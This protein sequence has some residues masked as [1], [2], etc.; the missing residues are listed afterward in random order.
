MQ[1]RRRLSRG[2]Q[3]L[4]SYTWA[5]SFDTA[6]AG[7][8]LGNPGNLLLAALSNQNRGPSDFDI[9]H[10]VSAAITYEIPSTDRNW[11]L[12]AI[13][14]GWSIDNVIQAR[15]A[16]PVNITRLQ[17]SN[18]A[19]ARAKVRPDLVPG[20][21]LFLFGP[22]YPGGR[23]INPKA[24]TL[25]P[26]DAKGNPLRQG[27]LGRNALRGFGAMQ[28]DFALHREFPIH[29]SVRLQFR[30]EVFNLLNHPNFGP[31]VSTLGSGQF[32]L[33]TQMLGQSLNGGNLG[34]GALNPLYQIGGPRSV[35]LGVKLLF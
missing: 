4:A 18:L 30:T 12:K 28:W 15:S 16:P 3:A 8:A 1:F 32:G 23:A 33:S 2:L 6:S 20:Q 13:V 35:Q 31:P 27:N 10:S 29:E 22:Q 24:F 17:Y 5:H 34:G 25:P 9:R 14:G 26:T 11:F 7:S 21:P 19:G